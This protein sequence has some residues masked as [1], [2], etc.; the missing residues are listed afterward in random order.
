[1]A[2]ASPA[3]GTVTPL[4]T[5]SGA[6][7]KHGLIL[8]GG[9][10]PGPEDGELAAAG[11]LL[12]VGNAGPAMWHAFAPHD[13]EEPDPLNRWTTRVIEPIAG[14]FGARALY[15]FGK[16]HFPFQRWAERSETLYPSPLGI[17]IHPE[18]G[19]WHAFRAALLFS[20]RLPLPPRQEAPNPCESCAEKPCLSACPVNAFDGRRYDVEICASHL[21]TTE[22]AR[23][24]DCLEMGCH[25]RNACPIGAKWRYPKAQ[26]RFHMAA[27]SRSVASERSH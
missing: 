26:I 20:K 16:P 27:F 9:F 7:E 22:P 1:L 19:L 21:A 12:L 10:H 3:D 2:N 25:A 24:A 11:T 5:L 23:H 18:Y 8:R 15:P 14:R 4:A 6:L 13:D 17:L